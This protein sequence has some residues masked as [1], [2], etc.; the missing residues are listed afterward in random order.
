MKFNVVGKAFQQQLQAVSKVINSKNALAILDN[1]LLRVEGDKLYITGSDS[2]NVMTAEVEVTDSDG[3]G[4]IAASAKILLDVTKEISS[5]PI[6]FIVDENNFQIDV[7][8]LT[9]HFNFMGVDPK[10]Y[11][12]RSAVNEGAINFNMP[13]AVAFNGLD[14]TLYAVS[15]EQ[16]R[17]IMTGIYWDVHPGDITFV[18]SDTHKLVRYI[19]NQC[20]PGVE[21]SFIM[22]AK[23]A[24]IIRGILSKEEEATIEVS[25]DAKSATFRWPGY[26]LSCR[27]IKGTYPNY[28]RVI[29]KSNPF[30]L[31]VDRTALSNALRRV[32]LFASKASSLVRLSLEQT[33]VKLAAQ[34]PDYATRAEE[35]VAA[36]Y[37]GTPMTIGFNAAF[38]IEV[39]NNL[40]GD[41][42]VVEFSDPA[43]PGVFMPLVQDEGENI[44]TIEM[45]M[46]VFDY[47]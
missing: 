38:T 5:Q 10:E 17:P 25:I 4:M 44:V 12:Q 39:L 32:S 21:T 46:Q 26:E 18:A 35:T 14:K 41:M 30:K 16:I 40:P 42:T 20:D 19:N 15:T 9:G 3:D 36:D 47:D 34:D 1:F 24:S 29:P 6:T 2:E 11:P 43:R 31:T 33:E 27:L 37:Q 13:A 22:P 8:F 7:R 28:N 45:P 23:P